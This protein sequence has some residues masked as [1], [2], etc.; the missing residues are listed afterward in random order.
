MI[1]S[2][3]LPK[4]AGYIAVPQGQAA[5]GVCLLPLGGLQERRTGGGG[6]EEGQGGQVWSVT[7]SEAA[8]NENDINLQLWDPV[9]QNMLY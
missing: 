2:L 7:S 6:E 1:D 4:P 5:G 3:Y 8:K 9:P